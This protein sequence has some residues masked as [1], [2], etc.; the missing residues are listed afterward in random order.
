MTCNVNT[1]HGH[2][3]RTD[4]VKNLRGLS[5]LDHIVSLCRPKVILLCGGD[6]HR[7]T[8]S[9]SVDAEVLRVGHPSVWYRSSMSLPNG[10]E[11]AAMVRETLFGCG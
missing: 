9:W 11:T 6:V 4:D 5:M 7:A 2:Y 1:D 8:A 10:E 3:G